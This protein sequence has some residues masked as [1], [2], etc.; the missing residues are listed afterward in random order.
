MIKNWTPIQKYLL[1]LGL[2]LSIVPLLGLLNYAFLMKSLEFD[3]LS[4]IIKK[5]LRDGALYCSAVHH[6]I[7][8]YKL[9]LFKEV[10]PTVVA[11]GS[12]RVMQVR[13]SYFTVPFVNLGAAMQSFREGEH[14]PKDMVAYHKPEVVI[15]GPDPWW[16]S[17]A[18]RL[19]Q[20][21]DPEATGEEFQ[22]DTI[23][24]PCD[25][26]LKGKLSFSYYFQILLGKDP[27]PFPTIGVL[28]GNWLEGFYKDGSYYYLGRA[29]GLRR[30]SKDIR[31]FADVV[32]AINK[33]K[34]PFTDPQAINQERWQE[35]VSLAQSVQQKNIRLI[36]FLSPLPGQII[37]LMTKMAAKYAYID[38][39]RVR[40]PEV[41]RHYYDFY[42]PRSFG[43]CDCEFFDGWHAGEIAFLRILQEI[44]KDPAS[45]LAP[46]LDRQKVAECI[47]QYRCRCMVP[48]PFYKQPYTEGD[49]L[50]LGCKKN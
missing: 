18:G 20:G 15:I 26:F 34:G 43:S 12:S 36:V 28:V 4:N 1:I 2:C 37:D 8:H 9:S 11:L 38:E 19:Y 7:Y 23:F 21:G 31:R 25:W 27:N 29:A 6:V 44:A 47:R 46:Y 40:L 10:K 45:G 35:F 48:P 13:S 49:F 50:E 17:L 3:N 14:L 32:E 42:D 22:I 5:Q 41:T 16:F 39:L 33:G 30:V 24:L